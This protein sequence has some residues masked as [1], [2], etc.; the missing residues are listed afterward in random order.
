MRFLIVGLGNPGAEY[1]DTRHNVGFRVVEQLAASQ[2]VSF[3]TMR[4]AERAEFRAKGRFYVLI[5]PQTYMN[6]SGKAVRYWLQEEGIAQERLLVIADD[7]A[8]P[9]GKMRMKGKG[10]A[11]G[12]NGLQNIIEILGNA[13]W[14]RMRIGIGKEFHTGQQSNYVLSEW[15][16]QEREKLDELMD[17]A[18]KGVLQF[19]SLGLDRTMNTFNT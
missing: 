3:E 4:Y 13:D 18:A 11:G 16:E 14:A 12:H 7:L 8:L 17:K 9:F 6:L 15:S 1:E 2:K 5:K 10:G 19:G